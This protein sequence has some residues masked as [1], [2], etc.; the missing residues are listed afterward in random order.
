MCFYQKSQSGFVIIVVYV[1]DLNLLGTT[2]EVDEAVIYLKTEFE[3]K[4]LGKTKYCLGIQVEHLSSGIFLHQSTYTEKVLNRFYMDK[5]HPLTTPMVVRSL[6]PDKDPFRPR[7][8]DEE[9]LG[10]EIPYLGAIGALM[11]LANNTRPDIAFAV[12]LLA[13]FSSARMGSSIYFVIFVE[14]LI[15]GYSFQR[16]RHIS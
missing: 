7:E 15:L 4:D 12:N 9:V 14:P 10:P 5:S 8:D 11:Y 2:T 3:M 1:D 16:T 13:R 6:E